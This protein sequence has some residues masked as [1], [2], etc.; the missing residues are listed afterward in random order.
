[1]NDTN[2]E[3]NIEWG[4]YGLPETFIIDKGGIVKY[5]HVGPLMKRDQEHIEKIIKKL[6]E[7]SFYIFE[8]SI[9]KCISNRAQ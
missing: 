9:F 2:G 8:F 1:M 7:I 4:V 6:N 5:K 3:A